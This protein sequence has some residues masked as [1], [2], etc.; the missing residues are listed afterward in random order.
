MYAL[1]LSGSTLKDVLFATNNLR[2]TTV[3][4]DGLSNELQE[5]R[6]KREVLDKK[7]KVLIAGVLRERTS[8]SNGTDLQIR[9]QI[10]REPLLRCN[11]I[12]QCYHL[13]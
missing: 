5:I 10:Y 7:E 13:V 1:K 12:L 8:K 11:I 6:Q 3:L 9:Q 4:E 2:H